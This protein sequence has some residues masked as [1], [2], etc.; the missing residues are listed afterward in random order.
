MCFLTLALLDRI[1]LLEAESSQSI[2]HESRDY[3]IFD[4]LHRIAKKQSYTDIHSDQR[5]T[6]MPLH[7]SQFRQLN[8]HSHN[9]HTDMSRYR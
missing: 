4:D 6:Y 3:H 7:P 9:D 2:S 5:E 1:H 8:R